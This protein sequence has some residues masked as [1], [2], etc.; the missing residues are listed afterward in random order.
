M[1]GKD[2]VREG[3]V[4]MLGAINMFERADR[5]EHGDERRLECKHEKN[6]SLVA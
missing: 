5:R 4:G 1:M 3:A 2:A 6:R